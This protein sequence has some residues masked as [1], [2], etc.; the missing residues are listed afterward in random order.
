MG[1]FLLALGSSLSHLLSNFQREGSKCS[2]LPSV[3]ILFM[4]H[5]HALSFSCFFS[6]CWAWMV[7]GN[8]TTHS[9]LLML[10]LHTHGF[11]SDSQ[12][13]L[14]P[15]LRPES[16]NH[17]PDASD[18]SKIPVVRTLLL[19]MELVQK[20]CTVVSTLHSFPCAIGLA[21][22]PL[23]LSMQPLLSLQLPENLPKIPETEV[24]HKNALI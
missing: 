3:L 9:T 20:S 19:V 18:D 1:C 23:S 7:Q 21:Q 4:T 13:P 24:F 16:G 2:I 11:P 5:T 12:N 6:W 14:W 8:H 15:F 17:E 22:I 10:S